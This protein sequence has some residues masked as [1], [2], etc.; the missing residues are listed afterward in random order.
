MRRLPADGIDLDAF[1]R[2]AEATGCVLREPAACGEV[3]RF[4][5]DGTRGVVARRKNGTLTFAGCAAALL[6]R[7][8]DQR[9]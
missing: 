6:T 3:L 7:F 4:A 5:W 2:F 9:R 8:E 1:R